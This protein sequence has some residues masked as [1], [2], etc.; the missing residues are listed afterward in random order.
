MSRRTITTITAAACIMLA[1]AATALAEGFTVGP[2]HVLQVENG[3]AGTSVA[4]QTGS[5]SRFDKN[6]RRLHANV[7]AGSYFAVYSDASLALN[8]PI[9]NVENLSFEFS[10]SAHVGAGAPRI[11]LIL[12]DGTALYLSAFYCNQNVG[13]TGGTGPDWGRADFTRDLTDCTLWDSTTAYS[14]DGSR[15][16][17]EVYEASH[18]GVIVD[19]AYLVAD[20][21]GRYNLD[22]IALGTR[23]MYVRSFHSAVRCRSEGAC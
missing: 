20:E 12:D 6:T 9:L 22:R 10:E 5:D 1:T 21:P 8:R 2:R 15:T 16:A 23:R 7:V 19:Q 11:T 14:A 13:Q 18:P 3:G 4:W 17:I